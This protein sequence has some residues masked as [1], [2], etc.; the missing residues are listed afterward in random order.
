[1]NPAEDDV[2]ADVETDNPYV[3]INTKQIVSKTIH[4]FIQ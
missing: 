4:A 1:M 3:W 2:Q